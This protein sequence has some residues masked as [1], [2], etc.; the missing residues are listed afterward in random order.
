[1]HYVQEGVSLVSSCTKDPSFVIKDCTVY[2]YDREIKEFQSFCADKISCQ[3]VI[4]SG[5]RGRKQYKGFIAIVPKFIVSI[6]NIHSKSIQDLT[7]FKNFLSQYYPPEFDNIE[8]CPPLDYFIEAKPFELIIGGENLAYWKPPACRYLKMSL[9]KGVQ[10][11]DVVTTLQGMKP[12]Y[13]Q[14]SV[15]NLDSTY[16]DLI[17]LLAFNVTDLALSVRLEDLAS[18]PVKAKGSLKSLI[19]ARKTIYT[20]VISCKGKSR[21]VKRIDSDFEQTIVNLFGEVPDL[22]FDKNV[23]FHEVF[24][25]Y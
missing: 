24:H 9:S 17:R 1:M 19:L 8:Y 13:F 21:M 14:L 20:L 6:Q 5:E 18:I 23:I 15:Y 11:D 3:N 22:S 4:T 10:T 25:Y 16:D 2:F 7:K 12:T